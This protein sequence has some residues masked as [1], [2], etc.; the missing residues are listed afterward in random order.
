MISCTMQKK[1]TP[2]ASFDAL[3]YPYPVQHAELQDDL[4][5]AYMDEG[6]G[7]PIVMIHGLGSYAPAWKKTIA[8]LQ[9]N[10]R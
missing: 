10:H 6:K 2:I 5:I 3:E 7:Q 8:S 9:I 4:K 1:I